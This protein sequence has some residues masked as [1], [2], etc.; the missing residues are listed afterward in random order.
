[1]RSNLAKM[2][3]LSPAADSTFAACAA[4]RTWIAR[5]ARS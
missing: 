5:P 2:E 4:P 1:L 3:T